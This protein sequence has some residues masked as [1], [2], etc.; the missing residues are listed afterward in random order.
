MLETIMK[1]CF[2]AQ[3][4]I[5]DSLSQNP[6]QSALVSVWHPRNLCVKT[7]LK[8]SFFPNFTVMVPKKKN[9]L[10]VKVVSHVLIKDQRN[11]K[12][13]FFGVLKYVLVYKVFFIKKI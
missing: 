11:K 8:T 2:N 10:G 1:E 4:W 6:A 9:S 13:H 12:N 7:T 5:Q 3:H